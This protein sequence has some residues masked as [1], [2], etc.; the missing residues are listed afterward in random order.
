MGL[1]HAAPNLL[2]TMEIT[3]RLFPHLL[4]TMEITVRLFSHIRRPTD[5]LVEICKRNSVVMITI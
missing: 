3:V 4:Y 2:Y 5:F 1:M